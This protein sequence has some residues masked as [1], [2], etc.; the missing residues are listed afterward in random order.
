MFYI[1]LFIIGSAVGSFLNVLIDRLPKSQGIFGR[2]H[3]DY[4]RRH[5]IYHDL[6]PIFSFFY[7]KG[8]CRYCNKKFS[9]YYPFVEF[10]TGVFFI[11]SWY[12]LPA[13]NLWEKV[14]LLGIISCLIVISF[15]DIKYQIIS[16]QILIAFLIF[17][18]PFLIKDFKSHLIGA[19]LLY[20][21]FQFI[22]SATRGRGMGFGDVKLSFLIG[23]FQ[24]FKL[25]GLSVYLSF[26]IG[27][28]Y[29]IILLLF[30]LKK[31]KSKIA[32]GPFL[33]VGVLLTMFFEKYL[34]R[35]VSDYFYILK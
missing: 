23:V 24:G 3:C 6:I 19:F 11:L 25:G 4:C 30:R 35:I 16:D 5:L 29:G 2:S 32:F 14:S 7:L 13:Y 34:L 27:G 17:S 8:R 26:L 21:V 28:L 15:S 20:T 33:V 22:H 9:L 31:L 1:F 18:L 12:Y 10:L